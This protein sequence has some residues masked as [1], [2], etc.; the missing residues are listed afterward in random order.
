MGTW[1]HSGKACL[2]AT[3]SWMFFTAA[4]PV[5]PAAPQAAPLTLEAAAREAIAWHPALTQAAG[6][7]N[8]RETEV[9]VA[10]AGYSPQISAGLATGLDS[11]LTADW[12]PRPQ[13][14]ASQML[15]DFGK[16]SSAV[17][18]AR[19]GTRVGE[20]QMLLA[21]D[22]LVRD[23]GYAL[24]EVQ[25]GEAL[26]AVALEQLERVRAMAIRAATLRIQTAWR[27]ITHSRR[28]QRQR[29]ATLWIQRST[30][31]YLARRTVRMQHAA[32]SRLKYTIVGR[33]QITATRGRPC[34]APLQLLAPMGGSLAHCHLA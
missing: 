4:A 15:F 16:V 7:L 20:A 12:R 2:V 3:G 26:H 1:F 6:E 23:T 11:R 17:D 13:I 33:A 29:A 27:S 8:A 9:D 34:S 21:I 10:R 32:A 14:N 25:R 30:R 28:F 31:G 19:A 24:I 5:G 22:Q 18:L